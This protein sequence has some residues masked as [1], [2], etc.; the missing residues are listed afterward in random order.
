VILNLPIEEIQKLDGLRFTC[1]YCGHCN[2]LD[3]FEFKKKKESDTLVR[4]LSFE[5]LLGM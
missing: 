3:K 5:S 2:F 4:M 1:E